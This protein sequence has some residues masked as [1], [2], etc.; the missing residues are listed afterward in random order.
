MNISKLITINTLLISIVAIIA[1]ANYINMFIAIFFIAATG[2]N[3]KNLKHNQLH[4]P[5]F[6]I[7]LSAIG[8]VAVTAFN[9]EISR[10]NVTLINTL[11]MLISLKL[12]EKKEYRDF[13]QISLMAV[14]ILAASSLLNLSM[15]FV[16]YITVEVFLIILQLILLNVMANNSTSIITKRYLYRLLKPAL[17]ILFFSIPV[18]ILLFLILPRTNYPMLDF[19]NNQQTAQTGFSDHVKLGNIKTIQDNDETAFI[20]KMDKIDANYLYWRGVVFDTF[21]N[22]EWSSNHRKK[23][24]NRINA[25]GI[26]QSISYTIYLNPTNHKIMYTL[27]I[28]EKITYNKDFNYYAERK[29]HIARKALTSKTSYEGMS[30]LNRSFLAE[31]GNKKIYLQ[32]PGMSKEII[33]IAEK[34]KG[35]T[36]IKTAENILNY[37]TSGEFKYT[38]ENLAVSE[39]PLKEFLTNLKRGNCEYFASAMGILLRLNGVAARLVGGY[40]GGYYDNTGYYTVLQS[41]AHVWVEAYLNKSWHTFDPTPADFGVYTN[42]NQLQF[43]KRSKLFFNKMNYYWNIFVLNYDFSKQLKGLK[44]AKRTLNNFNLNVSSSQKT[45][46][47]AIVCVALFIYA[48]KLRKRKKSVNQKFIAYFDKTLADLNV[49]R[50]PGEGL[51]ASAEKISNKEIREKIQKIAEEYYCKAYGT[52]G[53]SKEDIRI[54]YKKLR[55]MRKQFNKP[56]TSA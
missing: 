19:L 14:F 41:N 23:D 54:L 10:I 26:K 2:V 35:E 5:R 6:L 43:M 53:I 33:N 22:N 17:V 50:K 4:L 39:T 11:V 56:F 47:F 51:I 29:E 21:H 16:I 49:I 25:K 34:L 38:Q 44:K 12:L 40:M 15:I 7:N 45:V 27:N 32:I 55:S 3:I 42:K 18:A 13:M 52:V 9:F 48:Y 36:H 31:V 24:N 37:L 20:A 46:I 28:P 1:V 30:H 8:V